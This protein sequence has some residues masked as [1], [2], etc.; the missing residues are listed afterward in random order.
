MSDTLYAPPESFNTLATAFARLHANAKTQNYVRNIDVRIESVELGQISFPVTINNAGSENAWI[1]SP[2]TTYG[3]YALE[4]TRRLMPRVIA[5]PLCGVIGMVNRRMRDVGFDHAVS[6]NNWL[7]STNLYPSTDGLNFRAAC[8]E[9]KSRWPRH[10]IWFRSLN[11]TQHAGWL[12]ALES[13]GFELIPT[14]QVY[15]FRDIEQCAAAHQNLRRDLK[16]LDSTQLHRVDGKDFSDADFEQS[17]RL[18]AMLYLDKYSHF[19]PDYTAT[20][21]KTWQRAGLLELTGFRGDDGLLRAVVGIFGQGQLLTAPIVGYDTTASPAQGLYRLLMAHVLSVTRRRSGILNLSAGAAH[22]KR[23]RGGEPV[24][25]YSGVLSEHL[26][27]ASRLAVR[28]LRILTQHLGV[29]VMQR[30]KL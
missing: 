27:P 12:N 1:C 9:L 25:E 7:L 2:L 4:E 24:I 21:I 17:E 15:L 30:F 26:P 22:F 16:L 14:R 20:F 28:R 8:D 10:A 19:N 5:W 23:L 6:I 29:P 11:Y 18:Y 3:R 13:V